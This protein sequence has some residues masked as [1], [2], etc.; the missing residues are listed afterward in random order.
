MIKS[1][2]NVENASPPITVIA[3]GAPI[4]PAYSVSPIAKGSMAIIVV[5]VVIKMGLIRDIPAVIN[6]R[7]RLNPPSRN[8]CE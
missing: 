8:N 3:N 7:S 5:I 2:N 1:V 6:A 4:A